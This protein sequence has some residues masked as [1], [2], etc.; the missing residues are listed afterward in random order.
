MKKIYLAGPDVFY[1]DALLIGEMKKAVCANY[2]FEGHFPFDNEVDFKLPPQE[3][4]LLISSLNEDMMR[5]CD[6]VVANLSPFR[7]PSAD[8]GTVYELGFMRGLGK[9]VHGY[10]TEAMSFYDRI[11]VFD[12]NSTDT[13]DSDGLLIENFGLHDN[14]MIDGGIQKAGGIFLAED[15]PNLI[16]FEKLIK[17]IAENA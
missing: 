1:P 9:E 11:R 13:H 17:R 3:L 14:L 7:G 4:G 10:S 2:G 16:V 5:K 8:V 15:A 6:M 12:L